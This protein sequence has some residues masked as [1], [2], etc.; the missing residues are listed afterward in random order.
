MRS[1]ICRKDTKANWPLVADKI[2]RRLGHK[3]PTHATIKTA[4]AVA[5]TSIGLGWE[6]QTAGAENLTEFGTLKALKAEGF[7]PAS[8]NCLFT[9]ETF[10]DLRGELP[11][12]LYGKEPVTFW[13][14]ETWFLEPAPNVND[15]SIRCEDG[16]GIELASFGFK[17]NAWQ[18][19]GGSFGPNIARVSAVNWV[20]LQ[21]EI[22]IYE[23]TYVEQLDA[24]RGGTE[25][26][27][28]AYFLC[29]PNT[30]VTGYRRILE[31]ND[32][33]TVLWQECTLNGLKV[34]IRMDVRRSNNL[35]HCAVIAHIQD[36]SP[37]INEF[38]RRRS[39]MSRISGQY[40]HPLITQG[41]K[42]KPLSKFVSAILASLK[43]N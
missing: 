14:T 11:F 16:I 42:A 3:R 40:C 39:F 10:G 27:R 22:R 32:V 9:S 18:V 24:K 33:G 34:E 4:L 35:A 19:E 37:A 26:D 36:T 30:I 31:T 6:T 41:V 7:D 29:T 17:K 2:A 38:E 12:S 23:H 8:E 20:E 21:H 13:P 25:I 15:V 28:T 43:L 5:V 1:R